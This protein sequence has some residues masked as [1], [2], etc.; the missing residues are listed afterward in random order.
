MVRFPAMRSTFIV[1]GFSSLLLA[2]PRPPVAIATA[3]E[4]QPAA[5]LELPVGLDRDVNHPLELTVCAT[6]LEPPELDRAARARTIETIELLG[7]DDPHSLRL[8]SELAFSELAAANWDGLDNPDVHAR[9]RTMIGLLEPIVDAEAH[10]DLQARGEGI[11]ALACA[12]VLLDEPGP[13]LVRT[14]ELLNDYSGQ[15]LPYVYLL[16]AEIVGEQAD[17]IQFY[18]RASSFEALPNIGYVE[19]RLAWALRHP[20]VIDEARAVVLLEKIVAMPD[21]YGYPRLDLAL[22][23]RAALELRALGREAELS[24]C[25]R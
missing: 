15:W 23:Q 22:R 9:L 21:G 2:C 24:D 7:P 4:P 11:M 19:Y 13:A 17:A 3:A 1:A 10:A 20:Q 18:E 25:S 16:F 12:H 14:E 8:A 5:C 6:S